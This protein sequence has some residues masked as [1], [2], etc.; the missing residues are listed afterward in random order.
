MTWLTMLLA[1]L[2][3]AIV[4]GAG[5][6][7]IATLCV[8]WYRISS[9]EGGAGYYVIGLTL[10]G[11]I[12]G[13]I[14]GCLAARFGVGYAGDR[15]T[16]QLGWG[17]GA[18]AVLLAIVLIITYMAADHVPDKGGRGLAVAWEIRLP[19]E[20]PDAPFGPRGNPADWPDEELKLQLVSVVGRN[21]RG[22][23]LAA[24]DRA[25]FRQENGQWILPAR[26]PL[27]TSKGQFCVNL[28]LGGRDDGF[29][30]PF[31]GFPHPSQFQWSDWLRTNKGRDKPADAAA[32]MY[33]FR[34]EQAPPPG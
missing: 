32:T 1:G 22:S 11:I 4:G 17:V 10:L 5:M 9:F 24:F 26:V 27:F 20:S 25:A 12:G 6:L 31:N 19:A 18:V 8:K 2:L 13:F 3:A 29:W 23:E 16:V 28:T 7:A 30:P 33:R 15:W 21:P 34:F 14:A